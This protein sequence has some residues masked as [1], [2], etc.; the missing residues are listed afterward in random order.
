MKA[1]LALASLGLSMSAHAT[2]TGSLISSDSLQSYSINDFSSASLIETAYTQLLNYETSNNLDLSTAKIVVTDDVFTLEA[3]LGGL[4]TCYYQGRTATSIEDCASLTAYATG[5]F[6]TGTTPQEQKS[7]N[8]VND[9]TTIGLQLNRS[10]T[11]ISSSLQSLRHLRIDHSTAKGGG[12][13]DDLYSMVGPFGF[14]VNA[15]GSWGHVDGNTGSAGFALYNRNFN[16]ALDFKIS[17]RFA[18]GILFGYTSSA[19]ELDRAQG[20]FDANIFRF[21]PFATL[22]P[23]ENTYIDLAAGYAKHDNAANRQCL[24]CG[25]G[26]KAQFETDEFN[27][28]AGTGYTHNIG[29][30]SLRGYGQASTIY[31]NIGGYREQGLLGAGSGLLTVPEQYVVSVTS[32]FGVELTYA[33]SLPFGVLTPRVNGEWVREYANDPRVT[34]AF[35]R[36]GLAA[37]IVSSAA[38]R[39]WGNMGA[40]LQ[41]NL[42]N[43][44]AA[45]LGYQALIMS[46]SYNH[47]LEGGLRWEF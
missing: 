2:I 11:Q 5:N 17:E 25:G 19:A 3:T 18:T 40:G 4:L 44:L 42:P 14:F 9:A 22:T 21:S 30:W 10:T 12:A 33:W 46:G 38:E 6:A 8:A 28:L 32:T 41:L 35:T 36:S 34:R 31:M 43:G 45:N 37:S 7:L 20:R 24:T 13:G 15:G 23:T 1:L 39:D 29:A 16:A 26:A 47:A 27:I